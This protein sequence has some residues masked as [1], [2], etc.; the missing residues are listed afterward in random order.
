M[1]DACSLSYFNIQR[2]PKM[3]ANFKFLAAVFCI[4]SIFMSCSKESFNI[5]E[6]TN[7]AFHVKNDDYLIPVMVRGNTASKKILLFIQGGP[8]S[9][10]LDFATIDYPGWKNT[11]EKEYAIA[12]YEQRGMG[13]IQG[14]FDMGAHILSTY[15]EDLHQV[16]KFLE[17]AYGAEVIMF[18]HSFGGS[19]MYRYMLEK[20]SSGIPVQYI[21]LNGP[22]T[23]DITTATLR[24]E[25]RREFL[26]NTANLEISRGKN[27]SKWN[28]VLQW[29]DE[30]PVIEKIAGADPYKLFDQW[31]AYVEANIYVN[32]AQKEVKMRDYLKMVFFS[33]YN[34]FPGYLKAGYKEAIGNALLRA[35]E[36]NPIVDKLS[37]ID[38]Q[39]IL[40]MTG[41]YDDVCAPEELTYAFDHIS[42]PKKQM[43]IIDNAGHEIFT[44]Q[45]AILI[46]RIKQFIQ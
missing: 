11:L 45:P 33:S 27:I 3:V 35:E 46:E 13:N 41:R 25:F 43:E 10:T 12:Y 2:H 1:S 34:S 40:I 23:D 21:A 36:A 32:Y 39:S 16:A 7:D 26:L 19:L 22:V 18:G 8:G 20:G 29:L 4:S 28:E 31:N 5:S 6:A 30:T 44:H 15:I 17:K 9:N 14:N 37:I 24:W 42:S 38:H